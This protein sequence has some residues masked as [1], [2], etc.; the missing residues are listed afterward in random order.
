MYKFT[1]YLV[2]H[3][4]ID[5]VRSFL[6]QFLEEEVGKYN[7]AEW[8]TFLIPNSEIVLN[9]MKGDKQPLTQNFTLEISCESMEQLEGLAR[10]Y[11]AEI[12]S[13][14]ATKSQEPYTFYYISIFGPAGICK[15]EA[16]YCEY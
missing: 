7:H 9:L 16:N 11:N 14:R 2:C 1:S 15:L 13:F 12:D 10:E 4:N 6:S 8:L 5:D 3:E